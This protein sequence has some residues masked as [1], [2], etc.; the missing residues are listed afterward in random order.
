MKHIETILVKHRFNY[1]E[2]S[3]VRQGKNAILLVF[4][5]ILLP[6]SDLSR[7]SFPDPSNFSPE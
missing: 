6:I 1:I 3:I 7:T 5:R 2:Q 4:K